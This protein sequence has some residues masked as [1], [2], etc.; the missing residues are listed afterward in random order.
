M[1]KWHRGTGPSVHSWMGGA[2]G[3]EQGQPGP[4]AAA[5]TRGPEPSLPS[6]QPHKAMQRG[7]DAIAV[8]LQAVGVS[9]AF[10]LQSQEIKC[11]VATCLPTA[12]PELRPGRGCG[13]PGAARASPPLTQGSAARGGRGVSVPTSALVD[14]GHH[15]A[16]RPLLAHAPGRCPVPQWLCLAPACTSPEHACARYC[17][18]KKRPSL[19]LRRA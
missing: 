11:N 10:F 9:L 13:Q 2:G 3:A 19:F 1:L 7:E 5:P 12:A 8:P 18:R 4:N 16:L 6:S 17:F 14:Q 15:H